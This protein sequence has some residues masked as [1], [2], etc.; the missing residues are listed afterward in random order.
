M[1]VTD[2]AQRLRASF[3]NPP[4]A[5]VSDAI[6]LI[7]VSVRQITSGFAG[8]STP[9][10]VPLEQELLNIYENS[11]EHN[12]VKHLEAFLSVLFTLRPILP[13]SS[14]ITWFDHLRTTLREPRLGNEA[15]QGLRDLLTSAL[16]GN[17]HGT[18]SRSREFRKHILE[19]YLFDAAQGL[20]VEETIESVNQSPDES[21]SRKAWKDNLESVLVTDA[22]ACPNVGSAKSLCLSMFTDAGTLGIVYIIECYVLQPICPLQYRR[23]ARPRV[24]VEDQIPAN[25]CTLPKSSS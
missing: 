6:A 3:D 18:E 11:V 15:I 17:T 24:F 13:A 8:S 22:L 25:R 19:L 5:P 10:V 21:E 2:I 9:F 16:I 7:S 4:R 14:I 12:S 23:P 20:S 1:D